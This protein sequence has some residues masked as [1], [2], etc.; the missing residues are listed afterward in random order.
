MKSLGTALVVSLAAHVTAAGGFVIGWSGAAPEDQPGVIFAE[1]VY[2]TSLENAITED[3]PQNAAAI[4]D[5]PVAPIE[6]TH[7]PIKSPIKL[8]ELQPT[9]HHAVHPQTLLSIELPDPEPIIPAPTLPITSL[10]LQSS[11]QPVLALLPDEIRRDWVVP[12]QKP[13]PPSHLSGAAKSDKEINAPLPTAKQ[14]ATPAPERFSNPQRAGGRRSGVESE[15]VVAALPPGTEPI[16]NSSDISAPEYAAPALG[17]QSPKYPYAARRRGMEGKVVI[18]A[19]VD[20]AGTVATAVVAVSS[21]HRLLDRAAL[22]TVKRW[23]FHPARRRGQ[24]VGAT[25]AIPITFALETAS[26]FAQE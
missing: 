20:R 13:R 15:S 7:R 26:A 5:P 8:S 24:A 16:S 6:M 11:V 1:I 22:S 4:K 17:N 19:V 25:I 2:E 21:G 9:A 18:E 12:R 23:I 3:R 10:G 14:K